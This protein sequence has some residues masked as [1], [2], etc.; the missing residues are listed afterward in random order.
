MR[1][2]REIVG[3]GAMEFRDIDFGDLRLKRRLFDIAESF[4]DNPTDSI[5]RAMENWSEAK[6]AYRFFDNEKVDSEQILST[7]RQRTIERLKGSEVTLVIQDT[8]FLNYSNLEIEGVGPIG[9]RCET[10]NPSKG[11]V[12]HT[13]LA[14]DPEAYEQGLPLGILHQKIWA[15]E[16]AKR[17]KV[18]DIKKRESYKW[19]EAVRAV[20]DIKITKLI[21]VADREADIYE[22]MEE[23]LSH[24]QNFLIRACFD[25]R[26][27]AD[28]KRHL[29]EE[30]EAQPVVFEYELDVQGAKRRVR[31]WNKEEKKT[32]GKIT[33]VPHRKANLEVRFKQVSFKKEDKPSLQIYAIYIKEKTFSDHEPIEWMLLTNIPIQTQEDLGQIISWYKMRWHIE[34]FHKVLKSGCSTELC[35]LETSSRLQRYITLNSIIAW[36]IYWMSRIGRLDNKISCEAVLAKHEWQALYMKVKKKK[37]PTQPPTL[38][39]AMIWIAKLGGFL[40]RKHD[41][42]PGSK[43]VW[44]GWQRL[45]DCADSWLIFQQ[46][47]TCG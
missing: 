45:T 9:G 19:I 30:L 25:R 29:W 13:A 23:V 26:L 21:H 44:L 12:M 8:T 15:R 42:F 18:K 14:L 17:S 3:W 22:F 40:G 28:K 24:D 20:E 41:G 16:E 37:P 35:R 36:R 31:K 39:E 38:T 47:Q 32:K 43:A 10:D 27:V 46:L 6:A 33:Y 4:L 34:N 2:Q 7:H 11:F 1:Q 5:N